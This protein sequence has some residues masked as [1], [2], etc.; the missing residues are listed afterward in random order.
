[1]FMICVCF[2][3]LIL[4]LFP[5]SVF[6]FGFFFFQAEDGI[7]DGKRTRLNSSHFGISYAVFCLKK[8]NDQACDAGP[9]W[10]RHRRQGCRPGS[11]ALQPSTCQATSSS[12]AGFARSPC[13]S[14]VAC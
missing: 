8:K 7:R 12:A 13:C 2:L 14:E 1:M 5:A 3:Y 10:T 4:F 6:Y 9:G 11:P